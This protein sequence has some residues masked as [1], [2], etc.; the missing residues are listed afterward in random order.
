MAQWHPPLN[1]GN[2]RAVWSR[3]VRGQA[4]EIYGRILDRTPRLTGNCVANWHIT[5]KTTSNQYEEGLTLADLAGTQSRSASRLTPN[6]TMNFEPI[7]IQNNTPYVGPL[8]YGRSPKE[9]AGMVR[10]TLAEMGAQ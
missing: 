6:A 5:V 3:K 9:P 7:H 4:L 10:V 8:E 1:T 2:I